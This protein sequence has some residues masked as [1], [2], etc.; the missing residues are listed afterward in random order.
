MTVIVLEPHDLDD[1]VLPQDHLRE[2][3]L[4]RDEPDQL[5]AKV[6]QPLEDTKVK[7]EASETI[8]DDNKYQTTTFL[9]L[10]C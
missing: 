2:L 7:L 3:L 5:T 1:T 8:D 6:D 4:P 9:D 10:Y